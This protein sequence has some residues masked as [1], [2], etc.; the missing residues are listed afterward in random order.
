VD[1][2]ADADLE[3]DGSFGIAFNL[4]ID[5]LSAYEL[6]Y[7]RQK[8][9][10]ESTAAIAPFDLTVEYLHLGGTLIV[11]EELPLK[12]YIVGGL[13][14]TRFNPDSGDGGD[15]VRFSMSLGGGLKFPVTRNFAVRLEA[16]GYL[17]VV[18]SQSGFFCASGSFGGVCA[19]RVKGDSF[20][21][22]EVLAGAAFAF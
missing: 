20:F 10:F 18:N 13:G 16:R 12:P 6:F 4:E 21:Q 1:S 19:V 15:D 17:T 11:N 2:D 9:S 5:E 14:A 8:T 7:S 3:S 22:Y